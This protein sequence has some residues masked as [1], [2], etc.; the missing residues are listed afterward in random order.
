MMARYNWA[1]WQYM[2]WVLIGRTGESPAIIIHWCAVAFDEV[3]LHSD[4]YLADE[5]ERTR[6]GLLLLLL[7][8]SSSKDTILLLSHYHE[9]G[10]RLSKG[11]TW[12]GPDLLSRMPLVAEALIVAISRAQVKHAVCDLVTIIMEGYVAINRFSIPRNQSSFGSDPSRR[13][14]ARVSM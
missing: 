1:P 12:V 7:V 13:V 10:L 3:V 8:R 11:R 14:G 5:K 9:A 6:Q 4:C 2:G